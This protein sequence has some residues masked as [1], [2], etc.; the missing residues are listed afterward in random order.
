MRTIKKNCLAVVLMLTLCLTCLLPVQAASAKSMA[1]DAY[2]A[3]MERQYSSL[4]FGLIYLDKDSIPEL[5]LSNG[6]IYTYKKASGMSLL[7]DDHEFDYQKYYKKKGVIYSDIIPG[8][9]MDYDVGYYSR[10]SGGKLVRLCSFD[11]YNSGKWVY[12]NTKYKKISKTKFNSLIKKR[13]GNKKATKI[14][15]HKNNASDRAK[16]LG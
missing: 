10:V 15:Y 16:Y 6:A 7:Q 8:A 5:V 3:Y 11:H 14:K 12:Y 2:R 13:V 1:L 9:V 4:E